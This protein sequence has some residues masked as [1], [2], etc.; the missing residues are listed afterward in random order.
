[1]IRDREKYVYTFGLWPKIG[2]GGFTIA[3]YSL[4]RE[5]N[6][7]IQLVLSQ[8]E[9]EGLYG[10]LENCGINMTDIYRERKPYF[11]PEPVYYPEPPPQR[12][13]T[14]S[15]ISPASATPSQP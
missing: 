6:K 12:H 13:A 5:L 8:E 7:P 10:E 4:F 2:N 15:S 14:E 9:F 11:P 3:F 1:M